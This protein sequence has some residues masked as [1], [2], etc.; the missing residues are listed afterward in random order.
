MHLVS[1]P[2]KDWR[3][4][5]SSGERQRVAL[6]RV[7][8]NEPKF[9]L[10]DEATNA[11]P[12]RLESKIFQRIVALNI[13][14]VSITHRTSLKQF[15]RMSMTLDCQGSYDMVENLL[16][17]NKAGEFSHMDRSFS[18]YP[19]DLFLIMHELVCPCIGHKP[20]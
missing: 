4:G 17:S 11:I 7:I 14:V 6:A 15:H 8:V 5:L 19:A 16:V 10:L 13:A 2:D 18:L 9:V 1:R 3:N 12:V 20:F